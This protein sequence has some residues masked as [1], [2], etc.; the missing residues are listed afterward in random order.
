[1]ITNK[2][3][4]A[5]NVF[6][7]VS[8]AVVGYADPRAGLWDITNGLQEAPV[9]SNPYSASAYSY[10]EG[11]NNL[12][13]VVGWGSGTWVWSSATG[14]V[15][16]LPLQFVWDINDHGDIVGDSNEGGWV[17]YFYDSTGLTKIGKLPGDAWAVGHALNNNGQVIGYSGD[18]AKGRPFIWDKVNGMKQ[19]MLPDGYSNGT[20]TG[21][22]EHGVV[23]GKVHKGDYIDV[24]VLWSSPTSV[25][26]LITTADV[27]KSEAV[28]INDNGQVVGRVT[29]SN[30]SWCACIWESDGTLQKLGTLPGQSGSYATAINNSG[31][32]VGY[33]AGIGFVWDNV[34]GM[35][36]LGGSIGRV[37]FPCDI[38]NSGQVSGWGG[39]R[40]YKTCTL[41]EAKKEPYD[42]C[43]HINDAVVI[44]EKTGLGLFVESSNRSSGML[45]DRMGGIPIG[46][47]L[48]IRGVMSGTSLA[49]DELVSIT[50]GNPLA[51]LGIASLSLIPKPLDPNLTSGLDMTGILMKMAGKV[52]DVDT[53]KYIVYLNDGGAMQLEGASAKGI[54]VYYQPGMDAPTKGSFITVIGAGMSEFAI[55]AEQMK[56][57]QSIY[58]SGMPVMITSIVCRNAEDIVTLLPADLHQ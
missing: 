5:I 27:V 55:L 42:T 3:H 12:G 39:V 6:V 20:A 47:R 7:L 52:A 54:K 25:R 2:L 57:G 29:M 19:L 17:G 10:A 31:Q 21:I 45:I 41:A 18:G 35:R 8:L 44:G 28:D 33:A 24:A 9:H 34:S 11:L 43:V 22:N 51:P 49:L 36:E 13:D 46:K 4:T 56:I 32:V 15:R 50:D 38:N 40:K 14:S 1:M 30:G 16:Y 48:C 37:F 26:I 53:E 23:V 58:P